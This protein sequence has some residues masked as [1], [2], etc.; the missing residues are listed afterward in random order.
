MA[1]TLL[2]LAACDDSSTTAESQPAPP[3]PV[4]PGPAEPAPVPPERSPEE[5]VDDAATRLR[6]AARQAGEAA[7]EGA[8]ALLEQGRQALEDAGPTLDRAGEI[9]GAIGQSVQE[10]AE[11]ARRDFDTAISNLEQRLDEAGERTSSD[12]G[13][14]A[15][16]LSAPD[17]LRAD[18]RAAARAHAAG[19]GPAYVGAWALSADECSRIDREAVENFAVITPTTIRR[20]EAVCNFSATDMIDGKATVDASCIAEGETEQ[21]EISFSMP[22]D[23]SLSIGTEPGMSIA[24][25]FVRC[26]LP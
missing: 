19:I 3:A 5:R 22:S 24:V 9:A 26:H 2:A 25:Q 11:R 4:E 15:A 14:P 7:R 1:L 6:D 10:L 18:T 23:D 21:R 17:L 20:A 12:P 8:D 13:N 16:R